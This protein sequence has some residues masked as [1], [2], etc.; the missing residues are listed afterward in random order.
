MGYENIGGGVKSVQ[1]FSIT[2]SGGTGTATISAVNTSKYRINYNGAYAATNAF[3][4]VTLVLTNSTTI[5]AT[6]STAA[7]TVTGTIED[8][9]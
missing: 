2:T 6:S 4:G 8:L 3:D 7:T 1:A 5:T 9:Y